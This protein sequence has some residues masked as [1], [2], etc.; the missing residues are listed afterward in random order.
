MFAGRRVLVGVSGGIAAY[1]VC[2]LVSDL[3]KAGAEVRV[4]LTSAARYFVQPLT[5]E[6]LSRHRAYG[7]EDFWAARTEAEKPLHIELGQWAEVLVLAP[8]TANTLAKLTFGLAD[9]LLSNIVL[10]SEGPVLLAPAMN[11]VMWE[12]EV[13]QRNLKLLSQTARFHW[14]GP[15]Q[16]LM[17]CDTTGVGRMSEVEELLPHVG[18]LLWTQGKRDLQGKRV[19]ISAGGT[20]EFLD[21]VR[22]IGNPSTGKMGIALAHSASHRGAKVMLVHGPTTESLPIGSEN[23]AV[24]SAQQM[25]DILRERAPEADFIVMNAAVADVRPRMYRSDKIPKKELPQQLELA[26]VPDILQD[27]TS[28]R[29]PGQCFIGF[30]AQTGDIQ[31]AA[32]EKLKR[33][34]VDFLIANPVD[35]VGVGFAH[36]NN[37]AIFLPRNGSGRLVPLVSKLE[38]AHRMWDFVLKA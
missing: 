27:L 2:Q 21:P 31:V 28:R 6:T 15:D 4:V 38:L 10:A 30:A 9:N 22:F 8:L 5:F 25:H 32:A 37:Q 20:R 18:S 1:K 12:Q 14:S 19:L 24:T 33:K 35:Q 34:D 29:T 16:G 26:P 17:A 13:V 11:T 23:L 7:D 36:E 3:I